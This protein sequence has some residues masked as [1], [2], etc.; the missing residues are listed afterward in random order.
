MKTMEWNYF[1]PKLSLREIIFA[2]FRLRYRREA[3]LAVIRHRFM[4]IVSS[5]K[6]I[7]VAG[8][9]KSVKLTN[10]PRC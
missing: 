1:S 8:A 10:Y 7:E 9:W 6:Q 3:F 4:Q 2:R 5:V